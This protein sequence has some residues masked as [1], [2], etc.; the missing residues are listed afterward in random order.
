M[1]V[2]SEAVAAPVSVLKCLRN[3]RQEIRSVVSPDAGVIITEDE[4]ELDAV[5]S[6]AIA[7]HGLLSP[8]P[9]HHH[10]PGYT[11]PE[12]KGTSGVPRPAGSV[13]SQSLGQIGAL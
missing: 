2:D 1:T 13:E 9:E 10:S 3:P 7:P 4:G 12:Q 11:A 8:S 5:G 6:G